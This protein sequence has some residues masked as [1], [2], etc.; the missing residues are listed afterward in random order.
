MEYPVHAMELRK[1]LQV[2]FHLKRIIILAHL[3]LQ[4]VFRSNELINFFLI[5][6][7]FFFYRKHLLIDC[8][9]RVSTHIHIILHIP[10]LRFGTMLITS[11]FSFQLCIPSLLYRVHCRAQY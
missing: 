4:L 9:V 7:F 5:F 3:N 2:L 11:T 1:T 8:D 6:H 10:S